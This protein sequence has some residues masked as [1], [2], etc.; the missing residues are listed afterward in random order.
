[1]S[2]RRG[3]YRKP[4]RITVHETAWQVGH[5]ITVGAVRWIF[6]TID[7]TTGDVVLAASNVSNHDITW[8]TRLDLLPE[9]TP[10]P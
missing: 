9:R 10:R 1:M 2:A 7:R 8:N 6:R 4:R 3:P 5:T